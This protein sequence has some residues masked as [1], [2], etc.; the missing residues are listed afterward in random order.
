MKQT[1]H[2]IDF[3]HITPIKTTEKPHKIFIV[4]TLSGK[5]G[6]MVNWRLICRGTTVLCRFCVFHKSYNSKFENIKQK[7][8]RLT[9]KKFYNIQNPILYI[10]WEYISVYFFYRS[11]D[12]IKDQ[13]HRNYFL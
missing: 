9:Y 3:V 6:Y 10:R 7:K 8:I 11:V 2:N 1:R 12:Q 5:S 13:K 4:Y